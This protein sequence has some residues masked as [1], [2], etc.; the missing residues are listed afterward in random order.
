VEKPSRRVKLP[1]VSAQ[2][3][4][5]AQRQKLTMEP[6]PGGVFPAVRD[7]LAQEMLGAG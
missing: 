7:V 2:A 6:V 5:L 3:R 4:S 1:C